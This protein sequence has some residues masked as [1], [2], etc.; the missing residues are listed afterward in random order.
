ML[1]KEKLTYEILQECF[2]KQDKLIAEGVIERPHRIIRNFTPE[3][4]MEYN[5]GFTIEEVFG[6]LEK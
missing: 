2:K 6:N 3:E 1:A 4:Q 5:S